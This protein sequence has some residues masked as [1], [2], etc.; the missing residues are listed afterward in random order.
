MNLTHREDT[1]RV[2]KTLKQETI[3][4]S[5]ELLDHQIRMAQDMVKFLG[6]N[7]AQAERLVKQLT[8][9]ALDA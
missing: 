1:E 9:A 4:Q 3:K 7:T 5:Q 2:L 8:A 6:E